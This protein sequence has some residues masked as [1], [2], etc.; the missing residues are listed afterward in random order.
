MCFEQFS[1]AIGNTHSYAERTNPEPKKDQPGF[2][3]PGQMG[4]ND[5]ATHAFFHCRKF[6]LAEEVINANCGQYNGDQA[7][8]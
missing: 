6:Y 1:N 7:K 5:W 2:F 3:I 8:N 4:W